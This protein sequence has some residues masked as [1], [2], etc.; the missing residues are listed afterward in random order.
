MDAGKRRISDICNFN[1]ILEIPFF[2][3]SY[4]WGEENWERFLDDMKAVSEE[5]TDYF[6]GSYIFKQQE[7]PS[8]SSIGDI[9]VVI[10]GQQRLTTL[11]IFFKVLCQLQS[12]E[13]EFDRQFKNKNDDII[14]RHNHNDIQAF[15]AIAYD[16]ITKESDS[17]Y[18][19]SGVYDCYKYFQKNKSVIKD[20]S[21]DNLLNRIYF[22]GIDLGKDEDEQQIF[23]TINSL[24]VSL[25]TAELLK[26]ELFKKVED[27]DLY[28]QTWNPTFEKDHREYW[29][30][31]VTSGRQRRENIDLL[32]QAYLFLKGDAKEKY[33]HIES[34]FKNYKL[35]MK[36]NNADKDPGKRHEFIKSLMEHA[37]LYKQH[38]DPHLTDEG[39][40][41]ESCIE[42]LNLI[43]FGLNMTTIIPYII[44]LLKEVES[45]DERES[46]FSLLE[47]YL[48]RRLICRE[49]TKNYN[50]LFTSLIRNKVNSYNALHEKIYR[51]ENQT[52]VYPDNK[53]LREGFANSKLS[54]QQA[55]TALYLLE[56]SMRDGQ[57]DSTHI[58]GLDHYS[59]EHVMPK[60]WANKWG[61]NLDE[62]KTRIRNKSLRSLGNLTIITSSLNSSIK[63]SSWEVKKKGQ[64]G[65][66]GLEE[67]SRGIKIFDRPEFLGSQIWDED[68]INERAEFLYQHAL[69][70]WPYDELMKKAA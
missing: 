36:D 69:S 19:S 44:Y 33:T 45:T 65:K 29:A 32:L 23:D 41:S 59:L 49:T 35:L 67:Y 56:M 57:K 60:K 1:R 43:I 11:I 9:R 53:T 68:K 39:V 63:D 34:L 28:N 31:S 30:Q 66:L 55:K 52:D 5:N 58:Y 26:N 64:N 62:E 15:E 22:V 14:L 6:L 10:D 54:N 24:G 70:I 47:S 37:S 18:K 4:V 61:N 27:E 2:Q 7:T 46:M 3:R 8:N 13:K 40:D 51:T 48:I 17:K 38:I 21:F 12:R 16:R 50:N 42:R 20:I 25:T